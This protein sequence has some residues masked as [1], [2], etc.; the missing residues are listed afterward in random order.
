MG[1]SRAV[2][3]PPYVPRNEKGAPDT[4]ARRLSGRGDTFL[5]V[6]ELARG[7]DYVVRAYTCRVHQL[8]GLARAWHALHGEVLE[9]EGVGL[10]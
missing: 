8:F 7:I 2:R 10:F 6:R 3:E 5:G 9:V 1:C 4:M